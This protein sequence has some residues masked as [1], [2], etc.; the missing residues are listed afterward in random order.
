MN[1]PDQ[2]TAT[3]FSDLAGSIDAQNMFFTSVLSFLETY[4]F[5]GVDID[6]CVYFR[7]FISPSKFITSCREYPVAPERSGKP[8]DYQ[9]YVTFLQNFRNALQSS[10]HSYGLSI[11]V[12][13]P[14]VAS[15]CA[16]LIRP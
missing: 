5:D 12:S 15:K 7:L 8:M 9:N 1:D 14:V 10:G 6:W 11:T 13:T 16:V 4:G 3:T 2:P